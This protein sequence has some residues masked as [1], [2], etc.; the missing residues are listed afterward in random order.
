MQLLYDA[1]AQTTAHCALPL[2][3]EKLFCGWFTAC[4]ALQVAEAA[5]MQLLYDAGS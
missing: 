5:G 1:C 4:L 3:I 2:M